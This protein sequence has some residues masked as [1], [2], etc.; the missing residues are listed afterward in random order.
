M[1]V[2]TNTTFDG[3]WPVGTAAVVV[4][5]TSSEAAALL[6]NLLNSTG[7]EQEEHIKASDMKEVPIRS[8]FIRILNDGDY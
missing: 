2:W 8:G 1:K 4:A 7:L 3:H 6:T 5:E